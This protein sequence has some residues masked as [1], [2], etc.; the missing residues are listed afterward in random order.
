M[1]APLVQGRKGEFREL[2]EIGAQAGLHPRDRRRRAH[3]GRD[4]AEAEPAAEPQHLGRRRSARRARRG[5]RPPHRFDRDGAQ[6]RRRHRRSRATSR[7]PGPTQ[8]FSERYGCP[9][10]GISLPELEPRHFSFNSPFG[11]CT[12]LR[13]TRHAARVSEELIL[14]DPSISILEGVILPWGEPS[15]YLRKIDAAGAGA[16]SSSST[17]T[18]RGA[19]LAPRRARL[20]AATVPGTKTSAASTN[21]AVRGDSSA[22]GKACSR[23]S[24]AATT[25]PTSDSVRMELEEYMI[26][27]PCPRV[28]R[29][30]AQARV[31]R[32]D[33]R[34]AEHRRG[35]GAC[36]SP[37][38]SRFFESVP[39]R[40]ERHARDSIAEIAGPIL[41]EVRERLR[42]LVD[43]GLDYLTL[44]RAA[45]SLSGG[46]A[47]R[48][49]LATQIGSRLVGV[50]YILD[51]PS[52]GLHQRDNAR[53]LATLEQLRDLG[54]TVIVVE[55]DE[56]TMRAAD[57]RHRHGSGRGQ[58]RRRLIVAEGTVD[59][60]MRNPASI[61]GKVSQ[62]RDEDRR[63]RRQRRPSP[64]RVASADRGRARA[65][66]AQSRRRDSARAVR[67]DHR[68]VRLGKVD[69][70]RGH[71]ASA[72]SRGTSIARA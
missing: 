5:S 62:R 72:R 39:V 55:H 7:V 38:R 8:L 66:P 67:R 40:G 19:T 4:A 65:Q 50:L 25:R 68:R 14:G 64:K 26:E 42:F 70:D 18:R 54:N 21:G 24:S 11:A 29:A 43:V 35:R 12:E 46:E 48:I 1:R 71:S 47:Q 69:A 16:S 32:G 17:S 52:I 37:R 56:E 60:I 53:L 31:A 44:G 9:T 41:K 34:R 30:A 63:C 45:E 3:R 22:R 10:C 2:F 23:T 13:R 49:R 33:D 59:E 57:S 36:R 20:I 61:T 6:A 58:A 15:G 27:V 28:Q 51:E